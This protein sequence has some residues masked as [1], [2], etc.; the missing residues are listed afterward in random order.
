MLRQRLSS[1]VALVAGVA[2]A[3]L[4]L[5]TAA[6][7]LIGPALALFAVHEFT[8]IL[9]AAGMPCRRRLCLGASLLYLG[10]DAAIRAAGL[11]AGP[12]ET[13]TLVLA[14]VFVL[15]L[16]HALFLRDP[17]PLRAIS[18]TLLVLLYIPFLFHFMNRI[19]F[20]SDG[21]HDGRAALLYAIAVV[22][23]T[24]TCAYLFGSWLGRNRMA[25]LISPGKTWEGSAAGMAGGIA[26]GWLICRWTGGDLHI[27][28]LEGPHVL[29]LPA[30]LAGMGMVGDLVESL[31]KRAAGVKDSGA[32]FRGMGGMLDVLDSLLLA[33]PT[34]YV[35]ILL[36]LR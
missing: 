5:P 30:L 29:I 6:A 33:F 2:A 11:N 27:V 14:G 16:L 8:G 10:A 35:Y 13:G 36:F 12:A 26:A 24:D 25:P 19:L 22:K 9:T 17:D 7:S 21:A 31:F 15:V 4:W 32:A 3:A 34:L 1:A 20:L 18:A 23:F 28:Q